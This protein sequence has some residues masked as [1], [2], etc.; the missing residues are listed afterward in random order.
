MSCLSGVTLTVEGF[1][2]LGW[3][4]VLPV[5]KPNQRIGLAGPLLAL[6]VPALVIPSKAGSLSLI[7][8]GCRLC[9]VGA[10]LLDLPSVS[11][12]H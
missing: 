5:S 4:F 11:I 12:D 6:S 10:H 3:A 9:M 2:Y 7:L 1:S 8:W